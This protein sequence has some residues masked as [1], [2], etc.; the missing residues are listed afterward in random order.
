MADS[1]TSTPTQTAEEFQ[2]TKY[3]RLTTDRLIEKALRKFKD[4]DKL[5]LALVV[6]L[7]E[8][9]GELDTIAEE[10]LNVSAA[11]LH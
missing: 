5:A 9:Q 7:I 3:D 2:I 1:N 10:G 4:G 11:Q 8:L 6:R